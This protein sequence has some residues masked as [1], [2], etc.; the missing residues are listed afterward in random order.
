[1]IEGLRK[2]HIFWWLVF[3][4][5]LAMTATADSTFTLNW[6]IPIN[7]YNSLVEGG[8]G[9]WKA[10]GETAKNL[11]EA[12]AKRYGVSPD[13]KRLNGCVTKPQHNVELSVAELGEVLTNP[14]GSREEAV[15]ELGLPVCQYVSG[16]DRWFVEGNRSLDATYAPT[17]IQLKETEED[18]DNGE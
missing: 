9:L 16:A 5:F 15:K 4:F 2:R 3:L 14:P 18:S 10:Q 17:R 11:D 8:K 6:R 7:F 13:E 12:T 1:M